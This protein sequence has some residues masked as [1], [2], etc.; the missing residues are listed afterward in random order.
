VHEPKAVTA[1]SIHMRVGDC[2]HRRC[3]DHRVNGIA[4]TLHY[5]H[6]CLSGQK[7]R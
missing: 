3:R 6:A 5:V 7:M 1:Q 4:A 2:D